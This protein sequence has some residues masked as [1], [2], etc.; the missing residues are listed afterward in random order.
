MYLYVKSRASA[1]AN[2]ALVYIK[3]SNAFNDGSTSY[4]MPIF[5]ES[6]NASPVNFGIQLHNGAT[7]TSTN[8]AYFGTLSNNDFVLMT[9]NSRR[10]TILGGT[11]AG[12]VG[13]G[14]ATPSAG[15]QVSLN[16]SQTID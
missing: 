9:N 5:C 12:R 13:I 1:H 15:L 2:T 11:N 8:G 7:S 10:L 3:C 6:S 16:V 4:D 14:T